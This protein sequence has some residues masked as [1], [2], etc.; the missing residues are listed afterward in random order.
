M[1]RSRLECA[2]SANAFRYAIHTVP[3]ISKPSHTHSYCLAKLIFNLILRSFSSLESGKVCNSPIND[4]CNKSVSQFYL[5]RALDVLYIVHK[6]LLFYIFRYKR[7]HTA[8]CTCVHHQTKISTSKFSGLIPLC[9]NLSDSGGIRYRKM[10]R[11]WSWADFMIAM[12]MTLSVLYELHWNHGGNRT[13]YISEKEI[14]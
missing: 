10:F 8:H 11:R 14:N 6:M 13:H 9:L 7:V 2:A 5:M 1:Q 3:A 12:N 4:T